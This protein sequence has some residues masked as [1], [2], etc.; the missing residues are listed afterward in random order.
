M[1]KAAESKSRKPSK[2]VQCLFDGSLTLKVLWPNQEKKDLVKRIKEFSAKTF[3]NRS[4]GTSPG[5]LDETKDLDMIEHIPTVDLT[6]EQVENL[7]QTIAALQEK[8]AKFGAIKLRLPKGIPVQRL[9]LSNTKR[10]L[11]VRQQV[12]PDLPKGKVSSI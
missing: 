3:K 11:T 4:R 7:I 1:M 6:D 10:K 9:N 2:K 12:L 5:K 8:F